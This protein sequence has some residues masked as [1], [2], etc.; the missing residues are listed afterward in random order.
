MDEDDER[1]IL[2]ALEVLN[3]QGQRAADFLW[4]ALGQPENEDAEAWIAGLWE[5]PRM[6]AH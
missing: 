3:R 4:Q 5:P 1:L 6:I 2:A